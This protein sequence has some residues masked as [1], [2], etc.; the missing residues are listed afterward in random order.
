[1]AT[2][3][4]T[5]TSRS[6]EAGSGTDGRNLGPGPGGDPAT[7]DPATPAQ[8]TSDEALAGLDALDLP[9]SSG[10]PT[11]GRIWSVTW[12]KIAALALFLLVWQIVVWSGWKPTYVLPGPGDTLPEFFDQLG[13]AEFWD[14][15]GRTLTRAG[16]GYAVAVVLGG[17]VGLVV[18]RF[19]LL[20]AAVGSF[21]TALQTMP[22]VVWVPLA[23]LLFKLNESAIMFVV[24]LG[25]APSVANGVIYGVDYVPP[26]LVRVG[27][28]MGARGFSLYRHVVA[29]AAFPSVLA[30]LKQ[31]WAFAWRSLMAG[32]LIVIVPGHPSIGADLQN[33]RD[34][35]DTVGVLVSMLTIFAIGVAVDAVFNILDRRMRERRGLLSEG[36]NAVRA[37]RGPRNGRPKED[38]TGPTGP[39]GPLSGADTSAV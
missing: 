16:E 24:V 20:R 8:R 10:R 31:G 12:P 25:A 15:F 5:V 6:L 23:I 14:A 30:G 35:S 29:P 9:V 32:E 33:A 21:I 36:S 18:A 28:S 38:P 26:L 27:R 39:V 22:S 4:D 17:V 34:L 1:M 37:A 7:G 13:T 2:D 19:G 3:T 11:A